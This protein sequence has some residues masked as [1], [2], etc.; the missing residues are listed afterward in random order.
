MVDLESGLLTLDGQLV[1]ALGNNLRA[2]KLF[3]FY[4]WWK[5]TFLPLDETVSPIVMNGRKYLEWFSVSETL[6]DS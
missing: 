1:I 2:A 6:I 3:W 4:N 5:D